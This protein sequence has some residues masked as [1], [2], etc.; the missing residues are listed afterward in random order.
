MI[1]FEGMAHVLEV[2][3]FGEM[4]YFKIRDEWDDEAMPVSLT[5]DQVRDLIKGLA[6]LVG[7]AQ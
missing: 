6:E 5:H 7:E 3:P 2:R 4:I 1:Q